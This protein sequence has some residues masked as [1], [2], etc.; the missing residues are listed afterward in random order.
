MLF[1][2]K[3]A[4]DFKC[5]DIACKVLVMCWLGGM[6]FEHGLGRVGRGSCAGWVLVLFGSFL[7]V[8][9]LVVCGF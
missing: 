1:K 5:L 7:W 6:D 8:R 9:G 2:R 3:I 4:C